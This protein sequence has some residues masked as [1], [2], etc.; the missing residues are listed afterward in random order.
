[1]KRQAMGQDRTFTIQRFSSRIYKNTCKSIK[2]I[3]RFLTAKDRGSHFTNET[4][5][6]VNKEWKAPCLY[7]SVR[8][9]IN[10]NVTVTD[11][12]PLKRLKWNHG[13]LLMEWQSCTSLDGVQTSTTLAWLHPTK[14]NTPITELTPKYNLREMNALPGPQADTTTVMANQAS[15]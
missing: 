1:M 10:H 14:A 3:Y 13:Q 4:T 2:K 8:C 5:Q 9:K 15:S 11:T 12:Q 7:I 6:M